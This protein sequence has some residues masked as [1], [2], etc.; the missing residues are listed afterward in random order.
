MCVRFCIK[1]MLSCAWK[2]Y[3]S[4]SESSLLPKKAGETH[5]LI[6]SLAHKVIQRLIKWTWWYI[7]VQKGKHLK[8]AGLIADGTAGICKGRI[9]TLKNIVRIGHTGLQCIQ[10]ITC[11]REKQFSGADILNIKSY[12]VLPKLKHSDSRLYPNKMQT[13]SI[14]GNSQVSK[15]LHWEIR[16][17]IRNINATS[18]RLASV[19]Y[20]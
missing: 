7:W 19:T 10:G 16:R 17:E 14:Y 18:Q 13:T 2:S 12:A 8:A 4:W 3:L 9:P 1:Q 11:L 20:S 6:R 15:V 5:G